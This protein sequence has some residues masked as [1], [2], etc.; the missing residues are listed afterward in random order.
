MFPFLSL[1]LYSSEIIT[2]NFLRFIST[3]K[4]LKQGSWRSLQR[5]ISNSHITKLH[6]QQQRPYVRCSGFIGT[7][8]LLWLVLIGAEDLDG[9]ETS[10]AILTAQ[11]FVLVCIYGTDLD[12]TLK[13]CR[14]DRLECA[15]SAFNYSRIRR[16]C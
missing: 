6:F 15:A 13:G 12:D 9:G 1:S 16:A 5:E 3:E 14:T 2:S 7:L 11:G 4:L 10:D 8:V